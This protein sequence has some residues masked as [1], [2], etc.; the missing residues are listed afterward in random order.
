MS[1]KAKRIAVISVLFIA[2]SIG[3]LY[4][5]CN[6]QIDMIDPDITICT[7]LGL[8]VAGGVSGFLCAISLLRRSC[9]CLSDTKE[10]KTESTSNSQSI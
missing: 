6:G 9:S 1:H 5:F 3:L 7:I 10:Y 8:G 2:I 4:L